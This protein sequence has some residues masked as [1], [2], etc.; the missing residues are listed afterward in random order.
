MVIFLSCY[1]KD[2]QEFVI[3]YLALLEVPSTKSAILLDELKILKE[4]EINPQKTRFCCLDGANS[5]LGEISGLQRILHISPYS[6]MLIADAT[7]W[8]FVS[9]ISLISFLG[10]QNLT[11]CY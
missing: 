2:D 3:E 7:D 11:S 8:L 5:M 10:W 4:Q 9:N 1:N 6:C